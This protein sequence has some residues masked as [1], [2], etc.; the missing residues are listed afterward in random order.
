MFLRMSMAIS[1]ITL[2]VFKATEERDVIYLQ[3]ARFEL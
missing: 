3:M 1:F 2:R